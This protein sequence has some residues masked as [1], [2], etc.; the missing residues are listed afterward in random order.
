VFPYWDFR[1]PYLPEG[2][3]IVVGENR[4]IL[5][6]PM[7]FQTPFG[8]RPDQ[9]LAEKVQPLVHSISWR[10]ITRVTL[11]SPVIDRPS[12]AFQAVLDTQQIQL[13]FGAE[14]CIEL[15]FDGEGQCQ[16]LDFRSAL[17][18]VLCW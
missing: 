16:R 18:L 3:S 12:P 1:P 14:Y 10:E 9:L 8:Q 4:T 7:V 11:I 13:V 15:G 6:E 17:L 2:L 5:T